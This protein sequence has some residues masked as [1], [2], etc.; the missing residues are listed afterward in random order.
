[1]SGNSAAAELVEGEVRPVAEVEELEV[2]LE[3][4]VEPLE[5]AVVGGEQRVARADPAA[6]GHDRLVLELGELGH[7]RA[8]ASS[9][10]VASTLST[11]RSYS[12]SQCS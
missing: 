5:Q 1:M 10:I 6:L 11:Q 2:V 8:T 9:A 7:R 3:D 12:S 4:A